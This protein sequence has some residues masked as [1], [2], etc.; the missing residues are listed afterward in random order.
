MTTEQIENFLRE[1]YLD[2]SPVKISFK[3]RQPLAGIFIKTA[4][5]GELKSKNFWRIVWESN[6]DNYKKTKDISL[7]RIFNGTEITK[8]SAAV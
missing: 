1:K 4:D 5:Y 8:L 7:A 2:K 6:I 3:T